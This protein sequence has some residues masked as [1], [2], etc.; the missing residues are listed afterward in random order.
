MDFNIKDNSYYNT[1]FFKNNHYCA[2]LNLIKYLY[3]NFIS[4]NMPANFL[5]KF[6]LNSQKN[7]KNSNN[8]EFF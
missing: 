4:A 3:Y 7:G 6:K 8:I 5:K 1:K 2:L